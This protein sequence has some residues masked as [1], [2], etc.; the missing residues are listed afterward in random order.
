MK[1]LALKCVDLSWNDIITR[2]TVNLVSAMT[3][4]VFSVLCLRNVV[5]IIEPANHKPVICEILLY[6][7]ISGSHSSKY[8]IFHALEESQNVLGNL[9]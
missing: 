2:F 9:I 3:R 1:I 8:E 4:D 6:S 5:W 7:M